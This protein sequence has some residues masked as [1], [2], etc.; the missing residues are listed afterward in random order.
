MN[1]LNELH[2]EKS[3]KR[4]LFERMGNCVVGSSRF[5]KISRFLERIVLNGL[6]LT[7]GYGRLKYNY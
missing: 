7:L 3:R 2:D 4:Q 1:L 5:L 6:G